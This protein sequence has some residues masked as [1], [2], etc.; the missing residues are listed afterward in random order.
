M[1]DFFQR[2]RQEELFVKKISL[3][4]K[5]LFFTKLLLDYVKGKTSLQTTLLLI[6]Y[7][8][9]RK[10]IR[11]K[12]VQKILR[13][14]LYISHQRKSGMKDALPKQ[15]IDIIFQSLLSLLAKKPYAKKE[16]NNKKN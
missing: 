13:V 11:D 9:P 15:K 2:Q 6:E 12:A 10:N 7:F 14:V 4:H 3:E 1:I 16:K 8:C 5:R